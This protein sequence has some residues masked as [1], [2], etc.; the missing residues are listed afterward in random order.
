MTEFEE[1]LGEMA[2]RRLGAPGI[3]G[4]RRVT[5]GATQ[6]VWQ[7]SIDKDGAEEKLIL[8]RAPGGTRVSENAI[9]LA[10]EAALI[11]AAAKVG[12]P[13][14]P[15]RHV[16]TDEDGLGHGFIMGFVEGETLGGRIARHE[17]FAKARETLAFECGQVL[18]RIHTM[19]PDEFPRL[20]RQD[21]AELVAQWQTGY[22]A[23]DWPRPVFELT[24]RW[25]EQHCPPKPMRPRLVHG[26]FRNGNLII[27]P[28]GV[29]AVLDW[30][31]AHVGDP[32]EDLGWICV[33][34]WRFG[35]VD[36]PV[37][38]FGQREDLW[39]GY[40]AAGGAPVDREHAR[41][42]EVYGA[43]RWGVMCAGMTASFRG[44]DPSVERSVIA[45]RTSESEIDLMRLL[46][47]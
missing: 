24:F 35:V 41:F 18:A 17:S 38:G 40:E 36:K 21:P 12:A 6:E 13:V 31:L 32:M 2:R 44:A 10:T 25:L 37:G 9:G 20:K 3:T 23:S 19:D 45:R 15:V 29:R 4:L 43:M 1:L 28:D 8:R 5:A 16:L 33:N 46:A 39:A 26:D 22:R 42:W 34:S 11:E 47:A 30:E 27:G 7:F 14:P